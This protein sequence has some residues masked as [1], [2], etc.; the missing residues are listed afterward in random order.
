MYTLTEAMCKYC[1]TDLLVW[2]SKCW[3]CEVGLVFMTYIMLVLKKWYWIQAVAVIGLGIEGE[4]E[5]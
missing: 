5:Y 2:L 4:K 3:Y 1:E